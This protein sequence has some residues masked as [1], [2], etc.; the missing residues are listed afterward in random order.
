MKRVDEGERVGLQTNV[1]GDESN[2]AAGGARGPVRSGRQPGR[3]EPHR[4]LSDPV[5]RVDVK[6]Q[7]IRMQFNDSAKVNASNIH[8][9]MAPANVVVARTS[10]TK[11][12]TLP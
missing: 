7:E 3:Q 1:A 9:D 11:N 8:G 12:I 4:V 2:R 10:A 5:A 6:P